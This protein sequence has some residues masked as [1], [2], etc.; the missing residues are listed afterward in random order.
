MMN[1]AGTLIGS[2]GDLPIKMSEPH[3]A[4]NRLIPIALCARYLHNA[5]FGIP[6]RKRIFF[7][8]RSGYHNFYADLSLFLSS[9]SP[10]LLGMNKLH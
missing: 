3:P 10:F 1:T 2:H 8:T 4:K 9:G 6:F 5:I 7:S